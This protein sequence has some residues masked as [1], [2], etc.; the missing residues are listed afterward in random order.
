MFS[1]SCPAPCAP[2]G[3]GDE[4]E[5]ADGLPSQWSDRL[6][7]RPP[8][9]A[10]VTSPS[11]WIKYGR[12]LYSA[13]TAPAPAG[14]PLVAKAPLISSWR[15]GGEV[16]VASGVRAEVCLSIVAT[17]YSMFASV[18]G[19]YPAK[20]WIDLS[21]ALG[22]ARAALVSW[23]NLSS[24]CGCPHFDVRL[25]DALAA[26]AVMTGLLSISM[27]LAEKDP[28]SASGIARWISDRYK[29][30]SGDGALAAAGRHGAMQWSAMHAARLCNQAFSIACL[31]SALRHKAEHNLPA[32]LAL[33]AK[34]KE[35][36]EGIDKELLQ[37]IERLRISLDDRARV[38]SFER[39][40]FDVSLLDPPIDVLEG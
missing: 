14:A 40:H 7:P 29:E 13:C 34:A 25:V 27:D 31:H 24:K 15:I 36:T 6:L 18:Q 20:D 9:D 28:L 17:A 5:I 26:C 39:V 23:E 12:A 21:R 19:A 16:C 37:G 11:D 33:C 32:A 1:P 38:E 22:D 30:Y 10:L 35:R 8:A 3:A 4:I 2:W